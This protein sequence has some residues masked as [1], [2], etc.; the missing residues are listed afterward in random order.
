M[1][2]TPHP[3]RRPEPNPGFTLVELLVVIGII[4]LLISILL[5][6]LGRARRAANTVACL[7]N[8]RQLGAALQLYMTDNQNR[9]PLYSLEHLDHWVA[10]LAPYYGQN[11]LFDQPAMPGQGSIRNDIIMPKVLICPEASQLSGGANTADA[12]GSASTTWGPSTDDIV[13]EQA[14]SSYGFNG[15]CFLAPEI[16]QEGTINDGG[17]R[18]FHLPRDQQRRWVNPATYKMST[19]L[20]VFADSAW[21]DG[22]PRGTDV[23]P[24]NL[25]VGEPAGDFVKDNMDR[26]CIARHGKN[27]NVVFADGHASTVPLIEL[28]TLKWN[29]LYQQPNPLPTLP[30]Q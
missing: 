26:F 16:T 18:F 1:T 25:T 7:S 5:P 6:A 12:Y 15:W 20:P 17:N 13:F 27:V 3:T 8:V 14:Y 10:L 23:P 30:Q 29:G 19:E 2:I 22:W 28:W 4:A 11:K 9:P 24:P 21:E